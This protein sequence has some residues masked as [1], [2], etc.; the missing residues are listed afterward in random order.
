MP[1]GAN[2][3]AC[4][5]GAD[6]AGNYPSKGNRFLEPYFEA[7]GRDRLRCRGASYERLSGTGSLTGYRL[8]ESVFWI[9]KFYYKEREIIQTLADSP[10]ALQLTV[11]SF[12]TSKV[13]PQKK[14]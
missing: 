1:S 7:V 8:R 9:S 12:E 3:G 11:S 5:G 13:F 2:L 4:R 14:I 10:Y 6:C